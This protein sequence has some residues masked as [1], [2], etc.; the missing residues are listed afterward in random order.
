MGDRYPKVRVA[1]VQASSVFLDRE[2]TIEKSCQ[3]IEEAGRNGAGLIVFPETF[4][5]VY[6]FWPREPLP[7]ARRAYIQLF[8][9]SVD[10]P[11]PQTALLCDAARKTG[12]HVVMGVNERERGRSATLFNTL[13]FIDNR[14]QIMGKHRKLMPTYGERLVWGQG[15]GSGLKVFETEFGRL[16]GLICFENHMTLIRYALFALG[17][18]IHVAVWPARYRNAE[19]RD[20]LVRQCAFEGGVFVI[21]CCGCLTEDRVPDSFELKRMMA[22]E[23][24]G[25]SA[26]VN[27]LGKYLVEPVFDREQILYADLDLEQIIEAK[28][29]YDGT[30]HYARW[31]V[32]SLNLNEEEYR[33]FNLKRAARGYGASK[34]AIAEIAEKVKASGNEELIAALAKIEDWLGDKA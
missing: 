1:A 24:R 13:L 29:Y 28:A 26:I 8:N 34:E 5:P 18:Q 12:A 2:G 17:E 11:S 16:G 21:S 14:G 32:A 9:N 33:P 23:A 27:P 25:G 22:W 20:A 4:I 31:D 7:E 15:D 10:I 3:L 30:G 6:P 19:V